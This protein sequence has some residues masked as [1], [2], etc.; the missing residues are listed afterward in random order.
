MLYQK[1]PLPT[2]PVDH[3]LPILFC[4]FVCFSGNPKLTISG[5][6]ASQSAPRIPVPLPA[7]PSFRVTDKCHNARLLCGWMLGIKPKSL[8]VYSGHFTP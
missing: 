5:R 8:W 6:L 3:F 4:L 7:S 1:S 2:H